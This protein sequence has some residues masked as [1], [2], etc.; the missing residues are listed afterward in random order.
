MNLHFGTDG[1]RGVAN[2]D[3]TP[4]VALSLGRA[5]AHFVSA[6]TFLIGRDTRKSGSLLQAGLAAGL[7]SEGLDVI[8]VG[9]IP[10]PGLAYLAATMHLPAAMISASHNPYLDNGI[11]LLSQTGM[12]LSD[13][14]ERAIEDEL[15]TIASRPYSTMI[16]EAV[17]GEKRDFRKVGNIGANLDL[18]K[19]YITHLIQSCAGD[20]EQIAKAGFKIVCDLANGSAT[21]VAREVLEQ[22]GVEAEIIFDQPDGYNINHDCGSTHLTHLAS[23][24]RSA[25]A[26]FGLAFDGDADRVLAI[27]EEGREISGDQLMV[28]FATDLHQRKL[29]SPSA[30]AV[31]VMSNLGLHRALKDHG[32]EVISTQVGDRYV[33]DAMDANGLLL[34]GEQSGHII[35]RDKGTTGDGM[36]TAIML[37]ALLARTGERLGVLS[38]KAMVKFPQVL[39][40][41]PVSSLVNIDQSVA[42]QEAINSAKELLAGDGRVLVRPS[43]T[44]PVVRVMVEALDRGLADKVV[45]DL[46]SVIEQEFI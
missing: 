41:V 24:V 46:V 29:L 31:T 32:I 33:L 30:I 9:V 21:S 43:G 23:K 36:L 45:N 34:G 19:R 42:C 1:L 35:F 25:K 38:G 15:R 17:A 4:E 27:D 2:K 20:V 6:D 40:N 16:D 7:A 12:K 5:V 26:D 22:I 37:I 14:L 11:K 39:V 18:K 10:T 8:D 3:L 28:M 44:E 13:V